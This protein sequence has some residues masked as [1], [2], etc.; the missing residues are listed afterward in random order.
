[1]G[2][3]ECGYIRASSHAWFE[4]SIEKLR[5]APRWVVP[6]VLAVPYV[7]AIAA[8]R[9]LTVALNIFHGSDERVHHYP[10]ILRFAHQL[11]FPDLGYYHAAQTPLFHLVMAYIGKVIGY[12][13]WRLR[14]VEAVISYLATLVVYV[15]LRRRLGL[16]RVTSLAL[17]LLFALSPYMYGSSFRLETDN[18]ATLFVLVALERF[19]RF[20]QT[21]R[22]GPFLV[23]C[24]SV[25]AAM[26]TRQS[27]AF[28]IGV[29]GLYA[30]RSRLPARGWHALRDRALML[31]AV[32]L[33]AIP[34]GALFV[35]WHGLVPPGGD[36]SSCGLCPSTSS[37]G[38]TSQG[39]LV[40]QTTELA[41]A[42][43]GF[44]GAVLFAPALVKGIQARGRRILGESW[45]PLVGAAAGA[46]LLL[47]EPAR[48]GLHD[49]GDI[50]RVASHFPS[51]LGSSLVFWALVPIS[52]A[53]LWAR[54]RVC[55]P[56]R[57]WLVFVFGACFLASTLVIRYPWQKYVDPFALLT[58][59]LTVRPDELVRPRDLAGAGVLAIAFV[60]YTLSFV[61]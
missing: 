7:V 49:A 41:L 56:P 55:I 60:A 40:V 29:A 5:A 45:G 44:Y 52:G 1:M 38:Q 18:L 30:L 13:P 39:H 25:G 10:T 53:V 58:L 3:S 51:P 23:G 24:A 15:L 26:L 16:E 50:W 22:F 2:A 19:E 6:V 21:D 31:G 34:V 36:T 27:T 59:L 33:S 54:I 57:R 37:P 14:L 42:T 8:L 47:L 4:M 48:S 9:G 17:G 43:I 35:V 11:P 32:G 46:L 12:Q 28:M 20:R 61:L